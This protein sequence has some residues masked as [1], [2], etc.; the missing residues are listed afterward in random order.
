MMANGVTE[1]VVADA[2]TAETAV[3]ARRGL[4]KI[5]GSVQAL[6]QIAIGVGALVYIIA[7]SNPHQLAVSIRST[8]IGY[9]PLSL[10]ATL[11]VIWLMAYRWKVI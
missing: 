3:G 9:L 8:H 2:Q 7:K 10:A 11:A 6:V 4:K 1:N 5:P